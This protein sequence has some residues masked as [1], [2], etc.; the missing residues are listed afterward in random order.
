M[1]LSLRNPSPIDE[2]PDMIGPSAWITASVGRSVWTS[3]AL[4]SML[5]KA[6]GFSGSTEELVVPRVLSHSKSSPKL[7]S[8]TS[9]RSRSTS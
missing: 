3:G 7:A 6:N 8:V 4:N 1:L 5:N 9:S 2:S